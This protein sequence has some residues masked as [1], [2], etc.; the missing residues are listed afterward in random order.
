MDFLIKALTLVPA[1][2]QAGT[3]I[4][5]AKE[6]SDWAFGVHAQDGGPSE[7]DWAKLREVED[8]HRATLQG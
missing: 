8:A 6:F 7:A 4:S 2:V 1:L 3:A 5:E